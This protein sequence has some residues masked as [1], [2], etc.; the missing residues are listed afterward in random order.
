M[1]NT[2]CGH[3]DHLAS[4]GVLAN[5]LQ[6]FGQPLGLD[7]DH[8]RGV[9]AVQESA[10]AGNARYADV[11]LDQRVGQ[12]FLVVVLYDGK[13]QFHHSYASDLNLFRRGDF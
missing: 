11:A 1:R 2:R 13:Q 3:G 7:A 12:R 9:S 6:R 5:D 4:T 10:G 8:Q